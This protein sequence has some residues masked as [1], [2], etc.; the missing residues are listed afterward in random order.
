[1]VILTFTHHTWVNN[2]HQTSK[3]YQKLHFSKWSELAISL[4]QAR[5]Q[6]LMAVKTR[7]SCS[8][9]PKGHVDLINWGPDRPNLNPKSNLFD[10]QN[11]LSFIQKKKNYSWA[12]CIWNL[13][14]KFK[15]K[16][17]EPLSKGPIIYLLATKTLESEVGIIWDLMKNWMIRNDN[18][19]VIWSSWLF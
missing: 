4:A 3:H 15:F 9:K 18:S 12:C 10:F 1:M 6:I 19:G 17:L 14:Y 5:F 7:L 13:F 11:K 16:I 8:I 2:Q